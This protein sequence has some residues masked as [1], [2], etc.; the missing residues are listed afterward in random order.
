MSCI[1]AISHLGALAVLGTALA[2]PAQ[3]EV[4]EFNEKPVPVPASG[5]FVSMIDG[6]H[7]WVGL[8]HTADGG[9]T[10]SA[11]S[12][13]VPKSVGL[14]AEFPPESQPTTFITDRKGFLTGHSSVWVTKDGG[15]TWA[16]LFD[17][18]GGVSFQTASAGRA[19]V[20]EDSLHTLSH[21]VTRDGGETWTKCGES[22]ASDIQLSGG[23]SFVTEKIGWSPVALFDEKGILGRNGVAKTD[24][25]GCHWRFLTWYD[26][27]RI[28]LVTFADSLS[29]LLL[30]ADPDPPARTADGGLHWK[31]I[32]RPVPD[33]N[34]ISA[35]LRDRQHGWVFGYSAM[36]KPEAGLPNRGL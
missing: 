24:D 17:H 19:S 18:R 4:V 15:H 30:P 8:V 29:G 27:D 3:S 31:Q 12:P 16:R 6:D 10:W 20:W 28:S 32:R 13:A 34:P 23:S 22:N 21:Y 25:E 2:V 11:F 7:I 9:R 35:F 26:E 36:F 33:F 5:G 1:A 14:T